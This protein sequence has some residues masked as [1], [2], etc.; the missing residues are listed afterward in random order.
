VDI[1]GENTKQYFDL[2]MA[3]LQYLEEFDKLQENK[4]LGE[5]LMNTILG[6]EG[7]RT[8]SSP[9]SPRSVFVANKLFRPLGEII[10]SLS[11]IH[12]IAIYVNS[13]PYRRQRVSRVAYLRYHI[14]S[15]YE[16]IY[17]LK[18]RLIA[19]LTAITR[20]YRKS[21]RAKVVKEGLGPLFS[22]VSNTL[23]AYVDRR[24]AHVHVARYSDGDIDR[25][26]TLELLS[27]QQ[28]RLAE[29]L[30]PLYHEAYRSVRRTWHRR[31]KDD[32]AALD[33]LIDAYFERVLACTI[34]D[35]RLV[36]PDVDQAAQQG[37]AADAAKR[38]G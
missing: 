11:N 31:I 20:A 27:S 15:Y 17:I 3:E 29:T 13:F 4:E 1:Q 7:P 33:N 38:R 6:T 24:G 2:I 18:E 25:L 5:A 30:A 12:N 9:P 8:V 14:E 23:K 26:S 16:E 19:Y 22:I 34:V 10:D 32:L 28:G 21:D 36:Y 35:G 37:A